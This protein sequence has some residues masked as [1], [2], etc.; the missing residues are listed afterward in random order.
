[1]SV[2]RNVP[3]GVIGLAGEYGGMKFAF[4]VTEELLSQIAEDG[5]VIPANEAFRLLHGAGF[6]TNYE[7]ICTEVVDFVCGVYFTDNATAEQKEAIKGTKM[8]VELRLYE[9]ID[10]ST[11]NGKPSKVEVEPENSVLIG[12]YTHTF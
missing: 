12:T 11:N 2:D 5:T 3:A 1:M 9:T 4:D 6:D 7:Q 8:T 10:P